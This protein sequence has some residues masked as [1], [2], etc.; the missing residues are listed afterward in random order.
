MKNVDT[1][2]KVYKDS[3]LKTRESIIGFMFLIWHQGGEKRASYDDMPKVV[4]KICKDLPGK[5]PE[6]VC[7]NLK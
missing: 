1:N 5:W 4:K 3:D 6:D 7:K 2:I